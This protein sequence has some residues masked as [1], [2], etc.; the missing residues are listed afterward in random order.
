MTEQYCPRC[1]KD[2]TVTNPWDEV[3]CPECGL[4]GLWY[5]EH[6]ENYEDSWYVI[7]WEKF[8]R[9]PKLG[10]KGSFIYFLADFK[11]RRNS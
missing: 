9:L 5:E 7:E 6:T 11:A 8:N 1:D 3:T 4:K 2:V 10:I